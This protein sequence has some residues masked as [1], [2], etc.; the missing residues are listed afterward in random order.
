MKWKEILRKDGYA[1]LQSKSDTQYA[2]VS[3]YDPTQPEGQQWASGTYFC[4]WGDK[5]NQS[6][7]LQSALELFRYRTEENYISRSRLEE[8]AT[9]FKDEL[10]EY[11]DEDEYEE[12]FDYECD[13]DEYEKKFFEIESGSE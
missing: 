12:F 8:L 1:L 13:M 11:L 4:Y 10:E 3:G 9:Q 5:G 2:V 6:N 7:Y